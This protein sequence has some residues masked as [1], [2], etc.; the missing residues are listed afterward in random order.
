MATLVPVPVPLPVPVA[1]ADA[2]TTV[3]AMEVT[4]DRETR[5]LT[6]HQQ[7]VFD[8]GYRGSLRDALTAARRI[9]GDQDALDLVHAGL[10]RQIEAITRLRDPLQLPLD[11]ARFGDMLT[12]YVGYASLDIVRY[13]R[14]PARSKKYKHSKHTKRYQHPVHSFWGESHRPLPTMYA[15]ERPLWQVFETLP[16]ED[17]AQP[18]TE[19]DDDRYLPSPRLATRA[20]YWP[21]EDREQAL[22][23]RERRADERKKRIPELHVMLWDV[24]FKLP[25]QQA[26]AVAWTYG[27]AMKPETIAQLLGVGKKTFQTHRARGIAK[28]RTM[29]LRKLMQTSGPD[30]AYWYRVVRA[31]NRRYL[32]RQAQ[33]AKSGGAAITGVR[34]A[35]G[36]REETEID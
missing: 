35:G 20:H 23:E 27:T 15:N 18:S 28:A 6:D 14:G 21:P 17:L 30:A 31:M 19:D 1:V 26:L 12:R 5:A 29:L 32:R 36:R 25:E 24:I 9:V 33:L 34:I 4:S 16:D 3:S 10:L 22:E 8:R 11:D 7:A 2:R 13:S